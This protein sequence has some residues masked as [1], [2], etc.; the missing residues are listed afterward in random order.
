[1]LKKIEP[2]SLLMRKLSRVPHN[3]KITKGVNLKTRKTVTL[4]RKVQK[5]NNCKIFNRKSYEGQQLGGMK[6]NIRRAISCY[7]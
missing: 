3:Y 7:L 4:N 1:M 6:N 2:F 5:T